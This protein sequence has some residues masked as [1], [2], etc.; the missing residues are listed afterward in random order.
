MCL[1]GLQQF[2]RENKKR[3]FLRNARVVKGLIENGTYT[4]AQLQMALA[5]VSLGL[6][7]LPR[8]ILWAQATMHLLF[9]QGL[10]QVVHVLLRMGTLGKY[11]IKQEPQLFPS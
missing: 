4:L 7:Q 10:F 11:H 1:Y 9:S 2:P 8:A 5:K 3:T 6:F